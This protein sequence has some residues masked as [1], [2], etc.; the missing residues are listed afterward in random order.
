MTVVSKSIFNQVSVHK[1]LKPEDK[2]P[3]LPPLDPALAFIKIIALYV[4]STKKS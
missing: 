4:L 3:P 2:S 1:I